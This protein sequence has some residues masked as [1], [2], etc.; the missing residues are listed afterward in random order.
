[1]KKNLLLIPVAALAFAACTNETT[2]YVG[3]TPQAKEISFSPIAKPTT[4]TS[5]TSHLAISDATFP[6]TIDMMV[7]AYDVTRN[8]DFFTATNYKHGYA[9]STSSPGNGQGYWG[10]ETARYWPLSAAYINFLAIANANDDNATGV[11]WGAPSSSTSP[12]ASKVVVV[13]GDNYAYDTKQHDFLY[14]IGKGEVSQNGNALIF[15]S[16]VDMTFKHAQS[17]LVFRVKAADAPSCAIKIKNIE[18]YGAH[19]AGTATITHTNYNANNGQN[20]TLYWDPVTQTNAYKSVLDNQT[21]FADEGTSYTLTQDFAQKGQIIVVPKMSAA[22]TYTTGAITKFKITYYLDSKEYEYEYTPASTTLQAGYK[23]TYDITFKLHEI[24]INPAVT[25]WTDG[26][27]TLVDIPSLVYATNPTFALANRT[28]GTY[29]FTVTGLTEGHWVKVTDD[30]GSSGN[31][32][33]TSPDTSTSGYVVPS[34]GAVT[35]TGT[36]ADNNGTAATSVITLKQYSDSECNTEESS[37]AT[38]VTITQA[39]M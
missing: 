30:H 14:A 32:T 20:T 38:T 3:D 34:G 37:F 22:D 8:R 19:F 12:Y 4:R 1:M 15:P 29:T 7:T 5:S 36:L 31:F 16:K 10:G 26:G 21:A 6:T 27:T 13:Q 25:Q 2:E 11:T 17:Y 33:V 35:I 18:I 24:F 23:Y 39:A 9:N 28:T